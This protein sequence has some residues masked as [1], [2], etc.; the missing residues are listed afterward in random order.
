MTR[1]TEVLKAAGVNYDDLNQYIAER[2]TFNL[3]DWHAA[4]PA[5]HT[6]EQKTELVQHISRR[7]ELIDQ[8]WNSLPADTVQR[9][10]DAIDED[11][12]RWY[13][14]Q[15]ARGTYT[16]FAPA[17]GNPAY[18]KAALDADFAK[19]AAA[20]EG[21]RN[22]TLHRVACNVFEFV[23][24][25]HV[26]H[27]AAWTELRRAAAIGLHDREIEGTLRSAWNRVGPRD[28]PAPTSIDPAAT[29]TPEGL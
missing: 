17:G 14:E 9:I 21:C 5:P 25:G 3:D 19:L 16:A 4:N 24:G 23:K 8:Y 29:I 1:L 10:R 28:V 7:A 18:V 27:D 13:Y 20:Q 6:P 2:D 12:R 26:N 11:A 22:D 15:Q